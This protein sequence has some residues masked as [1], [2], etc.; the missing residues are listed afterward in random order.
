MSFWAQL[1]AVLYGI[2]DV[3]LDL[4]LPSPSPAPRRTTHLPSYPLARCMHAG[5]CCSPPACAAM[6][7]SRRS[8]G[9]A[10]GAA[11]QPLLPTEPRQRTPPSHRK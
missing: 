7:V 1:L 10:F 6:W 4:F 11:S 5:T 9:D 8:C 2:L 3:Y